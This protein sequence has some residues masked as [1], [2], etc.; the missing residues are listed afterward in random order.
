MTAQDTPFQQAVALYQSGDLTGANRLCVSIPETDPDFP[1]ALHLLSAIAL[2]SGQVDTGVKYCRQAA[3]LDPGNP[4]ILNGLAVALHTA[5]QFSAALSAIDRAI[6]LSG[7]Q[8]DFHA[9]RSMILNDLGQLKEAFASA[10]KALSLDPT[11]L[12]AI[13]NKGKTYQKIGR[14]DLAFECFAKA[15]ELAPHLP[16]LVYNTLSA[17]NYSSA[18]KTKDVFALTMQ[19]WNAAPLPRASAGF[20][21]QRDPQASLTIGFVSADFRRHAVG[22]LFEPYFRNRDRAKY[23][24]HLY[25]NHAQEDDLTAQ[26]RNGCDAWCN[27]VGLSDKVIADQIVADGVDVLIDLSGLTDGHRLGVF[28]LKPAPVQATWLGYVASTGIPEIDYIVCDN[29]VLPPENEKYFVEQPMRL[30]DCYL[31]FTPPDAAQRPAPSPVTANGQIVFGSFNNL[32]KINPDV[33]RAWAT[34]LNETHG[35]RLVLKSPPLSDDFVRACVLQS[36]SE[37]GIEQDRL[38]LL[39]RTSRAEHL[40]AYSQIDIALDPFPYG[41]GITTAETLWM[42]VPV[43]TFAGDTWQS[44]AGYSILEAVGF[45]QFVSHTLED[46]IAKA[47]DLASNTDELVAIRRNMR[48]IVQSSPLCDEQKIARDVENVFA[49]MWAT[50]T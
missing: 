33:I 50:S 19:Y 24:V 27:I 10:D 25:S 28:A 7:A 3:D 45:P 36:F 34:I 40:E 46:Y 31:P 32:I 29:F 23:K 49:K 14:A 6:S 35:S 21:R 41:G 30:P 8:P 5:G 11:C 42:G 26:Y 16:V 43:I 9:S 20:D 15:S 17:I 47:K 37:V 18:H 2:A 39:G 12:V 1:N 13:S 44:R 22:H 38:S 4:N 48:A